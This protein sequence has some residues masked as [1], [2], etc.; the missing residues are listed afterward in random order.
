[1]GGW[2]L[3]W[4][5]RSALEQGAG[6]RRHN[7]EVVELDLKWLHRDWEK[8]G[9]GLWLERSKEEEETS[10]KGSGDIVLG[11]CGSKWAKYLRSR[12]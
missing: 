10:A 4:W 3:Q 2:E 8:L 11:G 5:Q 12:T 6:R 1:M 7:V 9:G